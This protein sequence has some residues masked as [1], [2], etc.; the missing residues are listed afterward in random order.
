MTRYVNCTICKR[1]AVRVR[2][3]TY[4][5]GEGTHKNIKIGIFCTHCNIFEINP[6]VIIKDILIAPTLQNR[7][8]R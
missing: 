8:R 5:T 3:E 6:N 2:G 1:R 7:M 4:V